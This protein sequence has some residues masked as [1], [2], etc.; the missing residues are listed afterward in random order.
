LGNE[1][2]PIIVEVIEKSF[3]KLQSIGAKLV[4]SEN[5]DA[6]LLLRI[7]LKTYL[8]AI[9]VSLRITFRDQGVS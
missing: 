4:A 7:I 2:L 8:A 1:G 5:P 6:A 9:R 3:V